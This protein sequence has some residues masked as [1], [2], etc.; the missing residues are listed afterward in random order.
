MH[1]LTGCYQRPCTLPHWGAIA[2]FFWLPWLASYTATRGHG[3]RHQNSASPRPVARRHPRHRHR[4][5]ARRLHGRAGASNRSSS[6]IRLR[7]LIGVMYGSGLW[8]SEVLALRGHDVDGKAGTVRVR[9]GKCDKSRVVGIDPHG[10]ALLD[11]WLERRRTLGLNG[12]HLIFATY[13]EHNLGTA[14]DPRYVRAALA[15]LGVK[16]G[17]EKRVHPHGLRHSLAFDMAMTGVPTH[18]IQAALGHSSLAITDRYVRHIA[19]ADVVAT[20]RSREW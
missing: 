6:G 2:P 8:L 5:L 12:R 16:A 11:A 4:W 19:P 7:A 17:I 3:A 9:H 10:M 20:M 15:K 14:L 1:W 18:Q 13:T